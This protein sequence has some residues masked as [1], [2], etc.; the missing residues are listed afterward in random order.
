MSIIEDIKRR[1]I[2]GNIVEKLILINI[3]VFLLTHY[4]W[5]I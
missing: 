4:C 5:F 3:G 1:Y 2:T